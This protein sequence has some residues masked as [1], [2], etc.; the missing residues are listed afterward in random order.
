MLDKDIELAFQSISMPDGHAGYEI[1]YYAEAHEVRKHSYSVRI[2]KSASPS[3]EDETETTDNV[4]TLAIPESITTEQEL[5]DYIRKK[6][7]W[8]LF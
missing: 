4:E 6:R 8:M 7:G 1:S 5:R 2:I 3:L